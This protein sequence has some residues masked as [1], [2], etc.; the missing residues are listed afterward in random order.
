MKNLDSIFEIIQ[1][2]KVGLFALNVGETGEL[3]QD[4]F[5]DGLL[6]DIKSLEYHTNVVSKDLIRLRDNAQWIISTC[7]ILANVLNQI[8]KGESDYTE[9]VFCIDDCVANIKGISN[10]QY[11]NGW[12]MPFFTYDEIVNNLKPQIESQGTLIEYDQEKDAF[13]VR[14][15]DDIEDEVCEAHYIDGKKYY[16]I[17]AASW[18]WTIQDEES[19][20]DN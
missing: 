8:T 10:Q 18:T 4:E 1:R 6:L 5:I 13:I 20:Y 9:K 19:S 3:A 16:G 15:S 17:G 11:W 2:L 7:G 12:E 14:Y